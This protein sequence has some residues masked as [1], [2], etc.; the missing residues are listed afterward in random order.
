MADWKEMYLNLMRDTNQ[1][2]R[3]LEE[4]QR[5]CEEMFIESEGLSPDLPP[6][7]DAPGKGVQTVAADSGE[8]E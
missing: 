8:K 4:S 7:L 3:V 1:A 2:I 5:K 6:A